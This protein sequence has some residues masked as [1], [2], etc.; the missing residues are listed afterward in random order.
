MSRNLTANTYGFD[1][2]DPNQTPSAGSYGPQD[3]ADRQSQGHNSRSRASAYSINL[4]PQY[5]RQSEASSYY[6]D[7]LDIRLPFESI[8][9]SQAV[10]IVRHDFENAANYR[11]QNHDWR[12][13]IA[14]ALYTG[15][16]QPKFWEG[17]KIPRA[18]IAVMVA[19]EQIESI[20]PKV[21]Q[22]IFSDPDWFEAVGR[23]STTPAAA[24]AIRDI[25]LTQLHDYNP[26]ETMRRVIKSGVFYGNGIMMVGWDYQARQRLQ[27]IPSFTPKLKSI[28]NPI[29]GTM[30]QIP[31]GKNFDR[32]VVEQVINDY[33]NQPFIRYIPLKRFYIDP[34]A[35]SPIIN[36]ARYC[37]VESYMH[38]DELDALRK[39]P[40]FEYMPDKY[41]L[42]RLSKM[43]DYSQADMT[44]SEQESSRRS[45][46]AP[47]MDQSTDPAAAR[48]K[49]IAYHT[50]DRCIWSLNNRFICYNK[51]NPIGRIT[52][53][54]SFYADLLDRFYAMAISDVAEPEQRVQESLL[55]ARFDELSL[56]I[57]PTTVRQRGSGTPLYQVRVRP[58]AVAESSDPKNDIIRQYP[59][60]ATANAHLESQASQLRVQKY[61]GVTDLAM[62]GVG[63]ASNPAAK[64]AT[65]AGI[66]G[67]ASASR[68]IYFVENVETVLIEPALTDVFEY[69][70]KFLDPNQMIESITGVEDLD[71]IVVFGAR[72]KF[73]MRASARM[74]SKQALISLLPMTFQAVLNPQLMGQ[75]AASG[76]TIDFVEIMQMFMDA[77]GYRKKLHIIRD[78]TPQEMQRL[79]KPDKAQTDLQLQTARLTQLNE[80]QLNKQEMDMLRDI[81]NQHL[82]SQ[83]DQAIAHIQA[84]S[85]GS[86]SGD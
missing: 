32:H 20:L 35:P 49:V 18:S 34:N 82:T 30:I 40:G 47:W 25:I 15:W 8:S 31:D 12:W 44:Q 43:N 4:P 70:Q 68:I 65:G 51:P 74:Q 14:D 52:F 63:T 76:K 66:Q 46:W 41:T 38:I 2:S 55:G 5:Q 75:L 22:A 80:M 16:K 62:I 59:M 53:H 9:D 1:I 71:P 6:P 26:R 57:H 84:A 61:T 69:D 73:E 17:T 27:Y 37:C 86:D 54:S 45:S 11:Y 85:S 29:D 42:L 23:R 13:V 10:K 78:L 56:A 3:P 67:Q 39:S 33:I 19:F 79:N 58:G 83:N 81:I 36:E 60:N 72:V 50:K 28:P 21:M 77:S 64:T 24:R 7:D 48:V